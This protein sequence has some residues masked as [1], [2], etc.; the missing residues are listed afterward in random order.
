LLS[1]IGQFFPLVLH[2]G[3]SAANAVAQSAAA[4]IENSIFWY[5]FMA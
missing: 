4:K 5:L 1:F 2:F 3:A